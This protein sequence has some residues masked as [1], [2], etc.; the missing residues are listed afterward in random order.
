MLTKGLSVIGS[1]NHDSRWKSSCPGFEDSAKTEI[2]GAHTRIV[3]PAQRFQP[4]IGNR[5]LA[6]EVTL[7]TDLLAA[8]PERIQI[9]SKWLLFNSKI[10]ARPVWRCV[11]IEEG[12]VVDA[13][14]SRTI[15]IR[16]MGGE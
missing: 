5:K 6:C 4:A 7:Y 15:S 16:E 9:D 3:E 11:G 10:G 2:G 8:R 14:N 13:P 1:D 12:R